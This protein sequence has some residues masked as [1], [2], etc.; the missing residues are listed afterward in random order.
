MQLLYG[1]KTN[2]LIELSKPNLSLKYILYSLFI[3][4]N[5]DFFTLQM[6]R[7]LEFVTN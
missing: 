2:T 6:K 7:T 5:K 4:I 3:K 1:N